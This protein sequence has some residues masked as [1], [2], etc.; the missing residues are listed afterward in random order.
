M[1]LIILTNGQQTTTDPLVTSFM[2][3][4]VQYTDIDLYSCVSTTTVIVPGDTSTMC[5]TST[6]AVLT[7]EQT[8]TVYIQSTA[9]FD[10]TTVI[11]TEQTAVNIES[12][13]EIAYT[14]V[15]T[16]EQTTVNIKSTE[17]IAYTTLTTTT[18]PLLITSALANR[19]TA[20]SMA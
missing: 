1:E 18:V 10:D 3:Y 5:L 6:Q 14:T 8:T 11:T 7:T 20:K 2:G 12:T 15:T 16:T 4:S 13:A 19:T 17:G 9:Q